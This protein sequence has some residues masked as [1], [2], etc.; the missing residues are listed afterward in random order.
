MCLVTIAELFSELVGAIEE[1]RED[2]ITTPLLEVGA[3]WLLARLLI[4]VEQ[5]LDDEK[6]TDCWN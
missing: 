2:S 4:K 6:F 3:S 1:V 5:R